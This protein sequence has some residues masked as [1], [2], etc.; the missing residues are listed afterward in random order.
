LSIK[1]VGIS[2]EIKTCEN[3]FVAE[4]S[5]EVLG[6]QFLVRGIRSVNDFQEEF[7]IYHTNRRINNNIETVFLMPNID[8]SSLRSSVIKGLV[9]LRNWWW[10]ISD[11]V[12][13]VVLKALARE[14][15]Y[16]IWSK[17]WKSH[18]FYD[19]NL[20]FEMCNE[21]Y[22]NAGYHNWIHILNTIQGVNDFENI[23]LREKKDIIQSLLIHDAVDL[24][25]SINKIWY[26]VGIHNLV[27]ATDHRTEPSEEMS[28]SQKVIHDVDLEVL[29]WSESRYD[30]YIKWVR[31]EYDHLSD[32]LW[33]E[34]RSDFLRSMKK[35][36]RI[37]LTEEYYEEKENQ[38]RENMDRELAGYERVLTELDR[39]IP[40]VY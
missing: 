20:K 23:H 17:T 18:Y 21:K 7:D 31:T 39:Q 15:A 37:Y 12:P 11:A 35:R 32:Q 3:Q 14:C 2:A 1:E 13:E 30:K 26:A 25:T 29:S 24:D 4:F 22:I 36:K 9:G 27:K 38:A 19:Y 10:N 8:L 6:A 33:M 16:E 28:R 5:N 34:G 40:G